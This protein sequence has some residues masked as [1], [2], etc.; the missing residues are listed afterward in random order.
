MYSE[1]MSQLLCL[2]RLMRSLEPIKDSIKAGKHEVVKLYEC[3]V[4]FTGHPSFVLCVKISMKH[5]KRQIKNRTFVLL[6]PVFKTFI[7]DPVANDLRAGQF[8]E[9]LQ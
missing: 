6:Y 7:Q 2:V 4:R 9:I 5:D 1:S 8:P 3:Y